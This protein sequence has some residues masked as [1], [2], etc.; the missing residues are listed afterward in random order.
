MQLFHQPEIPNGVMHLDADE[1]RHCIKVL[2]K[3]GGDAISITDG[4][5]YFYE[6]II[7]QADPKQC[8]FEVTARHPAP[9]KDFFI[10]I[11]ISPTKNI[12]RLEW[13]VEKATEIGVDRI[14]L[15]D[16]RNTERGFVK[17]ERLKKVAVSAMKQSVKATLPVIEDNLLQFSEIVSHCPETEKYIASVDA[18]NPVHLKDMVRQRSSYCVLIGPEG[19]FSPEELRT[20]ADQGF[21]KVNLGPARL[22]TETAG[23]VAC[24]V[25]NLV[26]AG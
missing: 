19:D 21:Q 22:R 1:S 13:F 6:A 2:R 18:A 3:R 8:A 26:N 7:T 10:H 14:S 15:M 12:D 23:V 5:G 24:V 20:A 25:L 17:T 11:A 4:K 16:C 9:E